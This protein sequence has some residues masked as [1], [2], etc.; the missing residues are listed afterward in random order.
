MAGRFPEV[1][2]WQAPDPRIPPFYR[3]PSLGT[4]RSYP[5]TPATTY[6]EHLYRLRQ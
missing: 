4:T 1:K 5:R 2:K 3:L 6:T